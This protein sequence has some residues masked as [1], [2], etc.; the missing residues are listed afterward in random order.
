MNFTDA[1][2]QSEITDAIKRL[3]E[4]T[5]VFIY[6]ISDADIIKPKQMQEYIAQRD[7]LNNAIKVCGRIKVELNYIAEIVNCNINWLADLSKILDN[8]I[9]YIQHWQSRNLKIRDKILKEQSE[10]KSKY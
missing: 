8:E 6:S 10:L 3:K 1:Q 4:L 9:Q 7:A 2:I 5:T